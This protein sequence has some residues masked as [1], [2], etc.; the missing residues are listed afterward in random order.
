MPPDDAA[1]CY[2][3]L[4]DL[5]LT[6]NG[7]TAD[8]A[9]LLARALTNRPHLTVLRLQRNELSDSGA[10]ALA[11][12]I[13]SG[14]GLGELYLSENHVGDRGGGALGDALGSERCALTR[15]DLSHNV[16]GDRGALAI[17]NGLVVGSKL[18]VRRPQ[19]ATLKLMWNQIGEAAGG[20][21]GGAIGACPG[22]RSLQLQ[23]NSLGER[24]AEALVAGVEGNGEMTA[25]GT[26]GNMMPYAAIVKLEE[27]LAANRKRAQDAV[28][29]RATGR[30]DAL[31]VWP[32]T[33]GRARRPPRPAICCAARSCACPRLCAC[34]CVARG[35]R[36][37]SRRPR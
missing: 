23:N 27:L 7:L 37:N 6:R 34:A 20:A 16:I 3:G 15:L 12:A 13:T 31:Q 18:V 10:V 5:N 32:C 19:L 29:E 1:C 24:S 26:D 9:G 4:S 17:A 22:L 30:L 11:S 33:R 2:G 14:C 36:G 35:S 28:A 21:L 25:V 8:C